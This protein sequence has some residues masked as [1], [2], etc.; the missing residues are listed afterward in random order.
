[1]TTA[2]VLSTRYRVGDVADPP[3]LEKMRDR[4]R[5]DGLALFDGACDIEA[6]LARGPAD[7]AHNRP[8]R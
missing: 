2:T 1:M 7:Y 6:M 4:I 5:S 3:T 8:P